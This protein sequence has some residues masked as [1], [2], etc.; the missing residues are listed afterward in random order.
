MDKEEV[1]KISRIAEVSNL[2]FLLGAGASAP[3]RIRAIPDFIVIDKTGKPEFVEVKF[4]WKA[5]MNS[6]SDVQR[7]EK[8]YKYW[9]A[10][11]VIVNCWQQPYFQISEP[12]HIN[13]GKLLLKPLLDE[14][15]WQIDKKVYSSFEELVHKY[16]TPTLVPTRK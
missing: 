6:K 1:K 5:E 9:N 15:N 12:P 13:K 7:L 16:L 11:L 2:S 4:R 10:K 3:E 8:L 14:K